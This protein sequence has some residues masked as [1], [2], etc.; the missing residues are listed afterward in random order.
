MKH[1]GEIGSPEAVIP[2][3][4]NAT[5]YTID[6]ENVTRNDVL[7]AINGQPDIREDLIEYMETLNNITINDAT[8][9]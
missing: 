3:F 8:V 5:S 9:V 4:K 1:L 2:S 6:G 7:D